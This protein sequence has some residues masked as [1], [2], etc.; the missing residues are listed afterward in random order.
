MPSSTGHMVLNCRNYVFYLKQG[1]CSSQRYWYTQF[2]HKWL[3]INT[4]SNSTAPWASDRPRV[5]LSGCFFTYLRW[6]IPGSQ[7]MHTVSAGDSLLIS[8]N[9]LSTG[10]FLPYYAK[11]VLHSL[12][13]KV[14]VVICFVHKCRFSQITDNCICFS[15]AHRYMLTMNHKYVTVKIKQHCKDTV[16]RTFQWQVHLA[17]EVCIS[18]A[19]LTVEI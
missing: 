8:P 10:P 12:S 14:C 6:L 19:P 1:L 11:V 2:N 4:S 13:D 7:W 3:W 5:S 18:S 9:P 17:Y 16:L 15:L